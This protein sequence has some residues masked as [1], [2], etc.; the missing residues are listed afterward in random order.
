MSRS[1]SL[2]DEGYNSILWLYK[3]AIEVIRL[4]RDA[5]YGMLDG[6]VW[7]RMSP[8]SRWQT[9]PLGDNWGCNRG[10]HESADDYCERSNTHAILYLDAHPDNNNMNVR[11]ELI[12]TSSPLGTSEQ[13]GATVGGV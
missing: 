11:F 4:A 9:S 8:E 13:P 12:F 1:I 2:V 5:K 7:V 6:E 3:D 10:D